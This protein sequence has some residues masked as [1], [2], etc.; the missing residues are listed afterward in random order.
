MTLRL[1][2]S[3]LVLFKVAVVCLFD[4]RITAHFESYVALATNRE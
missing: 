4:T 1:D 2:A 3:P